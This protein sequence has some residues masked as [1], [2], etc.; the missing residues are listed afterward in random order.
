MLSI[1][2]LKIVKE[3]IRSKGQSISDIYILEGMGGDTENEIAELVMRKGIPVSVLSADHLKMTYRGKIKN[4]IVA[5]LDRFTYTNIDDLLDDRPGNSVFVMLDR[6][7][8]PQNLGAIVRSAY[9]FGV[10]AVIIQEKRAPSITEAAIHA[11][12]GALAHLPV[13]QVVNL[14]KTVEYLKRKGFWVYGTSIAE[15]GDFVERMDIAGDVLLIFGS[16]GEGIRKKLLEKCDF[17]LSI[18]LQREFDSLNVSVAAGI[19]LY[20]V[21]RRFFQ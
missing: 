17:M 13:V 12:A 21:N 10:A 4:G 3:F 11:S 1:T 20:M 7:F 14:S 15:G 9:C 8:D 19:I 2:G 18:P 16:E 5:R 6:V